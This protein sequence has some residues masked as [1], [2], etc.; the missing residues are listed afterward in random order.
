[1][2]DDRLPSWVAIVSRVLPRRYRS[3]V[4]AD[5]LEERDRTIA[6][7]RSQVVASLWLSAH[8]MRSAIACRRERARDVR[9]GDVAPVLTRRGRAPMGEWRQ[10]VRSLRR[11]PWY[12][13]TVVI[14]TALGM[15]LASTVFAVVDGV[16]FK[17]LPY[18]E[19]GDLYAVS[20]RFRADVPPS[21]RI[22]EMVAP[23]DV[24]AWAEAAPGVFVTGIGYSSISLPDASFAY[25]AAVDR[26]FFDVFG[27]RLLA[28][29]FAEDDYLRDQPV[30][31]VIISHRLWRTK[32]D[33]DPNVIGRT[34]APLSAFSQ[35]YRIVGIMAADGFVP[36][37]PGNSTSARRL[38]RVDVLRPPFTEALAE[39]SGVAF[40]RVPAD[41]RA[42]VLAAIDRAVAVVREKAPAPKPGLTPGQLRARAPF[43]RVD[44][45]PL[46]DYISSRERPVFAMVFGTVMCLVCLVLLNGGALAAA[47]AQQRIRDLSLRRA[48]GARTRDLLRHALAEQAVLAVV[49]T[50]AGLVAA[51]MLL[52][53]VL[54]R[55]PEGTNLVKDAHIDWRVL[56]FAA[57]LSAAAALVVALFSVRVALRQPGT[58]QS[59]ADVH[60]AAPVRARM[61][62]LLVA[63]QTAIAF[64]LVL[65][66]ALFGAS[67]ARL[68]SEDPGFQPAR[69]FSIFT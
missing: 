46:R 16:L 32:F 24:T 10:A 34:V 50:M 39:R 8:V 66:G 65:T 57:L 42:E 68:W 56:V 54:D 44:L 40:A 2:R 62:R 15:A 4:I 22:I 31:P 1:M 17:P 58:P 51:P 38:N 41:K 20:G 13:A 25:A 63:A 59:L 64:A 7:G 55:L 27:V 33:G 37:L 53:L 47:R 6:A 48:L 26:R 30:M 5:L 11:T 43:D 69:A 18:P 23:N 36:P 12:A 28:G 3:E 29:G 49:G 21:D 67:L 14:V 60:S 45:V 9:W 52:A 19:P 61:S 35:P